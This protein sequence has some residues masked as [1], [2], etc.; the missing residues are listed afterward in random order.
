MSSGFNLSEFISTLSERNMRVVMGENNRMIL[1]GTTDSTDDFVVSHRGHILDTET[2]ETVATCLPIPENMNIG[3]QS[4][5]RIKR[6]FA[7]D[8]NN[9]SEFLLY[10]LQQPTMVRLYFD[11][12]NWVFSTNGQIAPV[13]PPNDLTKSSILSIL[14]RCEEDLLKIMDR[15][16]AEIENNKDYVYYLMLFSP[17]QMNVTYQSTET[18]VKLFGYSPRRNNRLV[19]F[20]K[21]DESLDMIGEKCDIDRFQHLHGLLS[22][23]NESLWEGFE[24]YVNGFILLDPRTGTRYRFESQIYR[25]KMKLRGGPRNLNLNNYKNVN[26]RVAESVVHG[27]SEALVKLVPYLESYVNT[28]QQQLQNN[29][30]IMRNGQTDPDFTR[31][32]E[33]T[34]K[35]F[36]NW[37][38]ENG[39]TI[40]NDEYMVWFLRY[41]KEIDIPIAISFAFHN[42]HSY[43]TET[44]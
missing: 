4:M 23:D 9:G 41:L 31:T 22:C 18:T 17:E 27:D 43:E 3:P 39:Y 6:T 14:Q 37:V 2:G 16:L 1:R 33:N 40:H 36:R 20:L 26:Y 5:E 38:T 8:I 24:K 19:K 42:Y 34:R 15:I 7:T 30:T 25:N 29:I 10:P 28:F 44:N 35:Y 12:E 13:L 11:R 32:M 21:P